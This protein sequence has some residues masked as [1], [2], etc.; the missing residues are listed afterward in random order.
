MLV[1]EGYVGFSRT[2]CGRGGYGRELVI[3]A[4]TD[5]ERQLKR[6]TGSKERPASRIRG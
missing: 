3:S 6:F 4:F 5:M 1:L 2:G